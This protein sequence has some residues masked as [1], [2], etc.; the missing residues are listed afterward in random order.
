M[1]KV[2]SILEFYKHT[3]VT[4]FKSYLNVKQL[5]TLDEHPT[6][7]RKEKKKKKTFHE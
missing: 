3:N 2:Y 6:V 7:S 1:L 4:C 5:N